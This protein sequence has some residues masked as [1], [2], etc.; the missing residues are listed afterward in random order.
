MSKPS[1]LLRA[2]LVIAPFF[3][4]YQLPN[5]ISIYNKI[6]IVNSA[7]SSK[8]VRIINESR[9]RTIAQEQ[10]ASDTP[11]IPAPQNSSPANTPPQPIWPALFLFPSILAL[12]FHY[13]ASVSQWRGLNSVGRSALFLHFIG[14]GINVW[15]FLMNDWRDQIIPSLI[16]LIACP[17]LALWAAILIESKGRPSRR[18]RLP[19][20]DAT[21]DVGQVITSAAAIESIIHSSSPSVDKPHKDTGALR[22]L[23]ARIRTPKSDRPRQIYGL[24]SVGLYLIA[25]R[26]FNIHDARE[27]SIF[28][29]SRYSARPL[30]DFI[31]STIEGICDSGNARILAAFFFVLATIALV[32]LVFRRNS[33]SA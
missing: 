6:E 22:H 17:A 16:A 26:T 9:E 32:K 2:I 8:Y 25:Y 19:S 5:I 4:I 14:I 15:P 23:L 11:A 18:P 30:R 3:F 12:L 21:P 27:C 7:E 1:L 13:V 29:P 31:Y 10:R 28:G 33:V 24:I 20:S